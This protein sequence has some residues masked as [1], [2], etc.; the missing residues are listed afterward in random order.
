MRERV[1]EEGSQ[2]QQFRKLILFLSRESREEKG[3][4]KN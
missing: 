2:T 3:E 1:H 4:E